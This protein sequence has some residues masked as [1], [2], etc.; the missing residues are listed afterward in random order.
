VITQAD[1]ARVLRAAK[2]A[3][4]S[5]VVVP[6]GEQSVIVRLNSSTK[7]EQAIDQDQEIVL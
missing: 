1:I 3:G 2:Q 7:P 4:F 6:V 5:E